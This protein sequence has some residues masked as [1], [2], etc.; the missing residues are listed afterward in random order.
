MTSRMD[1][2]IE[3]PYKTDSPLSYD[4]EEGERSPGSGRSS[5]GTI[6]DNASNCSTQTVDLFDHPQDRVTT[7]G[8]EVKNVTSE[9][10]TQTNQRTPQEIANHTSEQIG[11]K[12][13]SDT[14][15]NL[16]SFRNRT[17]EQ[18]TSTNTHSYQNNRP[19][20]K[21]RMKHMS[22]HLYQTIHHQYNHPHL[23]IT[24]PQLIEYKTVFNKTGLL[25]IHITLDRTTSGFRTQLHLEVTIGNRSSTNL[26]MN[27]PPQQL[28]WKQYGIKKRTRELSII[29]T[30][31]II[32]L[33]YRTVTGSKCRS[34][35]ET[36]TLF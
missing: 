35:Q 22:I 2:E 14:R 36:I 34:I 24:Q 4:V 32:I 13:H 31:V 33:Y 3:S 30:V 6:R 26:P 8:I 25:V 15:R 27:K 20:N 16:N 1:Y 18:G 23:M 12:R 10:Q 28:L 21:F 19:S 7:M 17:N 5:P 11:K 9:Q 29:P